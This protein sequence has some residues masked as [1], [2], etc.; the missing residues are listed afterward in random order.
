MADLADRLT[1]LETRITALNKR[2]DAWSK[3]DTTAKTLLELCGVG[4]A[5]ASAAVATA[6]D[7]S[8]F[9]NGR[10][11]AAWLGLVPKQNSSGGKTQLGANYQTRRP[12]F[13][14]PLGSRGQ[15][16]DASRQQSTKIHACLTG[17]IACKSDAP[18]M[19]WQ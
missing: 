11:F 18:V 7:V 17:F 1:D 2:I 15:N 19:L 12:L 3:Q 5:T 8:V 9:K 6:G 13:A 4:S 10:Q 14:N 16:G